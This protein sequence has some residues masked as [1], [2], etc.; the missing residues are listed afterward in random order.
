MA[1]H[2][3]RILRNWQF[4]IADAAGGGVYF[5]VA[6]IHYTT[7]LGA[8]SLAGSTTKWGV[9]GR[10]SGLTLNTS[11]G[12]AGMH[13]PFVLSRDTSARLKLDVGSV[14]DLIGTTEQFVNVKLDPTYEY[15]II[16][17]R[18]LTGVYGNPIVN[19]QLDALFVSGIESVL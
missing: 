16:E 14:T 15:F 1:D 18:V 4:K 13:L 6:A 12:A 2:T 17:A 11:T 10:A 5:Q 9:Y 8:G 3:R 19:V 7:F